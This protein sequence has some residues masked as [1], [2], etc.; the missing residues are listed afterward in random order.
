W[1]CP[2]GGANQTPESKR[3]DISEYFCP[4]FSL[5][6]CQD[7]DNSPTS[8][9]LPPLED[10]PTSKP[11]ALSY[12]VE[13]KDPS[14]YSGRIPEDPAAGG[15]GP[16]LQPRPRSFPAGGLGSRGKEITAES[17]LTWSVCLPRRHFSS[18]GGA[19]R[20]RRRPSTLRPALLQ[21]SIL[22]GG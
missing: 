8:L 4:A 10:H 9:R 14:P 21:L 15:E 12:D 6:W 18:A 2:V 11:P 20:P 17:H 1:V 13:R 3:K 5:T 7:S 22:A 16:S 19:L